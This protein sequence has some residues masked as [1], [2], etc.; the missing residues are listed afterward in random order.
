[1]GSADADSATGAKCAKLANK[2]SLTLLLISKDAEMDAVRSD[3]MRHHNDDA[4]EV[5]SHVAFMS[6]IEML[7]CG[8]SSA[9]RVRFSPNIDFING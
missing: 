8:E 9:A 7:I 5:E 6:S 1:M 2:W 4:L 3:N